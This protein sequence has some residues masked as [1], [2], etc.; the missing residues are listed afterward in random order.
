M[1]LTRARVAIA[2]AARRDRRDA[3]IAAAL[4]HPADP[5]DIRAAAAAMRWRLEREFPGRSPWD[6]KYRPGGMIDV[7]FIEQVGVLVGAPLP[8]WLAG[9][10]RLYFT[11]QGLLRILIGRLVPMELPEA[12]AA[13]LLHALRA[14]PQDDLSDS[15]LVDVAALLTKLDAMAGRV[16]TAFRQHIGEIGP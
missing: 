4:H 16:R 3:A 12:S 15:D 14:Q 13:A 10:W 2:P 5:A 11:V 6:M 1:A 9:A 7:E 8:G